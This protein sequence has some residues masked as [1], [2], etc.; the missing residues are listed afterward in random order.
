MSLQFLTWN[1]KGKKK[2][3]TIDTNYAKKYTQSIKKRE[4]NKN[5]DISLDSNLHISISK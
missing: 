5:R 2:N 1:E 3:N 4:K